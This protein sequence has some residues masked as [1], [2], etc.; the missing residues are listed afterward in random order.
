LAI[1]DQ[2]LGYVYEMVASDDAGQPV[3]CFI[4]D[5]RAMGFVH[6]LEHHDVVGQSHLKI[7]GA[8]KTLG[9]GYGYGEF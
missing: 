9:Y 5:L 4:P 3:L 6:R 8:V 1:H 7:S 2:E